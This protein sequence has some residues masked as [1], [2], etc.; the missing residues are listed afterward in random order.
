[1]TKELHLCSLKSPYKLIRKIH[2]E[3][4]GKQYKQAV[5]R[6]GT[7]GSSHCGSMETNLTSVHED[8]GTIPGPTQ[9]V[10]DPALP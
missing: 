6:I 4:E 1:M 10:E 8:A 5:H 9:W 7:L 3:R 2:L